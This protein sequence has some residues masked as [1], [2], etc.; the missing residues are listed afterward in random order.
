MKLKIAFLFICTLFVLQSCKKKEDVVPE[1]GVGLSISNIFK[2]N[3]V[4]QRD[5]PFTIWGNAKAGNNILINISWNSTTFH[6][7]ADANGKWTLSMP[8]AAANSN[9]QTINV[10]TAGETSIMLTNVLIG[11]VW[12]CSGQSN[13][14]MP[15]APAPSFNGVVNYQQEI[16]DANYP[17]IRVITI[18]TNS[19]ANPGDDI[20]TSSKWDVCSP[21][22][23]GSISA[24]SYFFARKL[25][26]DL[27]VP[28]GIIISAVNNTQ[29]EQ[30]MNA[31]SYRSDKTISAGYYPANGEY[32]NGMISPLI[33]L[34]VSGFIWYQGENNENDLNTYAKL[35]TALINGWRQVFKQGALPFYYVQIA[36]F[37]ATQTND[38]T[39]YNVALF[40]EEQA[41]IRTMATNSGMAVT[42][43]VGQVSNHHPVNKKPVGER[44]ALLALKNN[45]GKKVIAN[46]PTYSSFSINGNAATISFVNGTADGLTAGNNASLNQFFFVAGPDYVFRQ[47]SAVINGNQIIITAPMGTPLPLLAIRYAFTDFPITNLQNSSGLP[48]EPFRTDSWNN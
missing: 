14:V 26:I 12:I 21:A 20:S 2:S 40:R 6:T 4:I 46:G 25:Y 17:Q 23:V 44:L 29:C 39:L 3:M 34:S 30:W 22:T 1:K 42:M 37:D 10:S 8:P 38:N 11:D 5:K 43:D 47:G 13:M 9:P 35:N 18:A 45:Y 24:V 36:P 33:N 27:N 19:L 31:E 16:A 48:M 28:I 15:V 41:L 7:N 32:Y